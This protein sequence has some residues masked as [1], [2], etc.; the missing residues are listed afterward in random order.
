MT[1][2]LCSNNGRKREMPLVSLAS[3]EGWRVPYRSV[4]LRVSVV[5]FQSGKG[6]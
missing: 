2:C 3:Y 1:G 4:A 6:K 5:G